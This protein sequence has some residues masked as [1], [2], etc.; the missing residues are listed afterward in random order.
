M[1]EGIETAL[2]VIAEGRGPVWATL[3]TGNLQ[4][5]PPL[6]RY[7]EVH[8]WADNHSPDIN[9]ATAF[10]DKWSAAGH[11]VWIIAPLDPGTDWN[12]FVP[13]GPSCHQGRP[14][15][16]S[17]CIPG[18]KGY[19]WS[20][21]GGRVG[22]CSARPPDRRTPLGHLDRTGH[23]PLGVY[24]RPCPRKRPDILPLQGNKTLS[25]AANRGEMIVNRTSRPSSRRHGR[26]DDLPCPY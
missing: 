10:A 13:D 3:G 26:P 4:T 16:S 8:V 15:M 2:S 24:V 7:P 23:T 18:R 12:D 19:S 22:E 5:L 9:A 6:S 20:F 25:A 21:S 1:A 17:L 14:L 11:A